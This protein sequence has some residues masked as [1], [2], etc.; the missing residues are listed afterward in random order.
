MWRTPLGLIRW[1]QRLLRQLLLQLL[2]L[3]LVAA[4]CS[5]LLL[6]VG[7]AAVSCR[8][9][10]LRMLL[11]L[12]GPAL[13]LLPP[14]L[15]LLQDAGQLLQ[16]ALDPAAAVAAAAAADVVGLAGGP[17]QLH[18]AVAAAAWLAL[19]MTEQLAAASFLH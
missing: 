15:L 16:V 12:M 9:C 4:R 5:L 3:R 1:Q 8:S 14:L 7:L 13:R 19:W 10:K 17:W 6:L 2:L 18:T 11:S